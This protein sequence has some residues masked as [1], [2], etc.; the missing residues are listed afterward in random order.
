MGV[1]LKAD[2]ST[3]WHCFRCGVAG[4][5]SADREIVLRVGNSSVCRTEHKQLDT[6]AP[7]WFSYWSH[8]NVLRDQGVDYLCARGCAIPP[9]DGDLRFDPM[10]RH[11]SGHVGPAII[12]LVTD[13]IDARIARS[14]HRTWIQADGA[15]AS[16]EVPRMLLRRHRK[17]GGVIRLWPD[18]AVTSGLGLAEG[19]ES[20][21]SAAQIF[22]PMWSCLDAGNLSR[23]P[24]LLRIETLT[25]FGDHDAAG[26]HAAE[27]CA[28]RWAR[29]GCNVRI[30][31][32]PE[33]GDDM[34]DFLQGARHG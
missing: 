1:T 25:I 17:A 9:L 33:P 23:F 19:I 3:V 32:P 10:A 31:C 27:E 21:L 11:P 26:L 22:K 34:N 7:R 16:V 30:V 2:G 6:L 12:A 29:V 14:L 20:A 4:A 24:P 18:E 28:S 15:K 8:L 5:H 13:A